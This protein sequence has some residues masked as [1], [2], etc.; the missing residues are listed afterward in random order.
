ML[1]SQERQGSKTKWC[2]NALPRRTDDSNRG[3][4]EVKNK[5]NILGRARRTVHWHNGQIGKMYTL[6]AHKSDKKGKITNAW[7]LYLDE[8]TIVKV[9]SPRSNIKELHK[10]SRARRTLHSNSG[11]R[12]K[13]V[14]RRLEAATTKEKKVQENDLQLS[15]DNQAF[16]ELWHL[17]CSHK[18]GRKKLV[19]GQTS[20]LPK[21]GYGWLACDN[22]ADFPNRRKARVNGWRGW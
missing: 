12:W 8:P 4:S 10:I 5:N 13:C 17:G 21:N 14:H 15:K 9:V 16:P 6:S 11:E 19:W 18:K 3:K 2:V 7:L 1:G 20:R 22:P